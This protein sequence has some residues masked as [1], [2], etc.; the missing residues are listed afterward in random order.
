[1]HGHFAGQADRLRACD[2]LARHD[3]DFF[4]SRVERARDVVAAV[5]PHLAGRLEGA[6]RR[7]GRCV[8]VMAGQP[9]TLVHGSYKP[10]HILVDLRS[11]PPGVCPVDWELAAVGSG[12]YDLAFLA[13]G[14]EPPGLGRLLDAYRQEAQAYGLT[15]PD[16]GPARHAVDCFRLHRAL[17]ALAGA[18]GRGLPEPAVAKLVESAERL[19]AVVC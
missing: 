14:L 11:R 12:L 15:L 10:R 17:K 5:A 19:S 9:P 1:L 16:P 7:Y 6:L 3:A 8:E 18:R 13:Y 4:W 2:F